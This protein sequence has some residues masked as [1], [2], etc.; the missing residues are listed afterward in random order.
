MLE[1]FTR[2]SDYLFEIIW[3]LY[4]HQSDFIRVILRSIAVPD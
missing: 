1:Q 3:Q 2:G 4:L